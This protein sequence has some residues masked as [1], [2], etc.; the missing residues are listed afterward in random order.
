MRVSLVKIQGAQVNY[1]GHSVKLPDFELFSAE[2]TALVGPSGSGKTTV[3]HVLAG[4][5]KPTSGLVRSL[6]FEHRLLSNSQLEAYRSQVGMVFQDFH[7][8]DGYT[9]LENVVAVLGINGVPIGKAIPMARLLLQEVELGNRLHH[10]PDRLSTG[11]RQRVAIARALA[12]R[13]KLLLVDE[14]TAHLDSQ[15]AQLVLRLL[16]EHS[17]RIEATLLIATH[18]PLVTQALPHTVFCGQAPLAPPL[19]QLLEV[20]S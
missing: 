15:R 7:L 18:D 16:L 12:N 4:L 8:L 3:L 5:L 10:P 1:P 6:G 19:K 2:H 9:A 14:P 11:E 20:A 13:P 17:H